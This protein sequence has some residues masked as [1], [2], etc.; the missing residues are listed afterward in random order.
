MAYLLD[1]YGNQLTT[2]ADEL[3]TV[4]DGGDALFEIAA[5]TDVMGASVIPGIP[6]TGPVVNV[7]W[8]SGISYQPM[9][10]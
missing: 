6:I 5:A 10:R 1:A 4:P 2:D 3:L 8:I 9:R 7:A